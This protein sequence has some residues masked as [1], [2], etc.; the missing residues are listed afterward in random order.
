MKDA[1]LTLRLPEGL[2]RALDRAARERGLAKSHLV[3][4]AVA[5]YVAPASVDVRGRI[6]RAGDVSMA[7]G[8]LPRLTATEATEFSK[9]LSRAR[10]ALVPPK[11]AWE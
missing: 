4:E 7:W 8:V 9:D 10:K 6:V 5:H 11:A 3:R 2:A 1:H